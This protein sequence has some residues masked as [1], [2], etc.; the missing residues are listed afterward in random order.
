MRRFLDRSVRDRRVVTRHAVKAP[1]KV[2]LWKS[3]VPEHAG[4]SENISEQG[5]FLATDLRMVIGTVVEVVLKMPQEITGE[6]ET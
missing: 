5:M 4:R 3:A 2:R 1:V 6:P